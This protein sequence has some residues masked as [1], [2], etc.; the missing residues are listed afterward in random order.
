MFGAV[1]PEI[2]ARTTHWR[3]EPAVVALVK[4]TAE[5]VPEPLPPTLLWTIVAMK[6]SSYDTVMIAAGRS[7]VQVP[8]L[9]VVL[10]NVSTATATPVVES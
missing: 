3:R 2:P 4:P 10:V 6:R 9:L 7:S 8:A 1:L 5:V